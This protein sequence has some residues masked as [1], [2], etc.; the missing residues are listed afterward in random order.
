MEITIE[1][2]SDVDDRCRDFSFVL[3]NRNNLKEEII[4]EIIEENFFRLKKRFYKFLD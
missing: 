2:L 1:K 4:L 3:K